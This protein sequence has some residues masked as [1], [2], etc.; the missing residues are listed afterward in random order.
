[1]GAGPGMAASTGVGAGTRGMQEK[2]HV[3]EEGPA[4]GTPWDTSARAVSRRSRSR[5]KQSRCRAPPAPV[6]SQKHPTYRSKLSPARLQ[7][8]SPNT[9]KMG[10]KASAAQPLFEAG[11]RGGEN[12]FSLQKAAAPQGG[13][14]PNQTFKG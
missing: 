8:S 6:C 3:R 7:E 14:P 5:A 2:T 1:M 9:E 10:G 4:P 12:S 11:R 13:E